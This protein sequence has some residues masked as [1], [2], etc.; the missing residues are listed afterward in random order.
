MFKKL[1]IL[2]LTLTFLGTFSAPDSA[3]AKNMKIN[4]KGNNMEKIT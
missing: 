2:S 1:F 4:K 3:F